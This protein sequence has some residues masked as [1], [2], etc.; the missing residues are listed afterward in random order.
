MESSDP[1]EDV[2]H[3]SRHDAPARTM[4]TGPVERH[5]SI[6]STPIDPIGQET[7]NTDPARTTS[8][9]P[10]RSGIALALAGGASTVI[11]DIGEFARE[12]IENE[13]VE[14]ADVKSLRQQLMTRD[15]PHNAAAL[16]AELVRYGRLTP[17]QAAAVLQGKTKGLLIGNYVVLEKLGAGSMGIVFKARHRVL[18][19]VVALKLLP[20]SLAQTPSPYSAFTAR[21]RPRPLSAIPMLLPCS[22]PTNFAGCTFS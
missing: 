11:Q 14:T 17:Y 3:D 18:K 15:G 13:L 8:L 22:T 7:L 16:A 2:P 4:P 6:H 20:P 5:S 10:S 12:L 9:K 21:P 1:P 19:R